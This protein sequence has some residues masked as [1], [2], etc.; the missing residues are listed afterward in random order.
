[1][2]LGFGGVYFAVQTTEAETATTPTSKDQLYTCGMHPQ[3]IS[4]KP[5][6]CPICNMKLTPKRDAGAADGT[7]RIDPAT[8]QNMGLVTSAARYE[9]LKSQIHTFGE[10]A[11]PDPNKY[12]ITVKFDGWVERLFVNEEGKQVHRGEPLLEVYSPDLVTARKELLVAMMSESNT[13]MDRLAEAARNRLLNWDISEEQLDRLTESGEINRTMIIHSPVDGFVKAK[14]V[15]EGDRVTSQS[16]LYEITDLSTVWIKAT[17]YEQDLPFLQ[18][19]G[20]AQVSVPSLPGHAFK[21]SI[22]YISPI[23]NKQGQVEIRLTLNNPGFILKP[24]MYA[25]VTLECSL[26]GERL[27]IPRSAVINSG[28]RQLVYVSTSDDSYKPREVTTGAVGEND[29]IEVVDGLVSGDPVVTS[30]Q[31]LLDSETRLSEAVQSSSSNMSGNHNHIAHTDLMNEPRMHADSS[32]HDMDV[33]DP[34]NIHT[35]PMP[36]H[37]H[38]LHYGPEACPE[39]G[40]DLVPFNE[41]ENSPVYVCPMPECKVATREPGLCPVCN[42][43]LI[44]YKPEATSDR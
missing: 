24:A 33:N 29:M 36:A 31:F 3:I 2:I 27:V 28:I 37:Y 1:M 40:M 34:Y 14:Y 9:I 22:D 26:K 17:A 15:N 21:G 16:L 11:I 10:V 8:R 5:G 43:K 20:A 12:S 25:D 13:T 19:H 7:V 41:T 38:V 42:M 44:E 18:L 23:L 32:D 6:I 4:D 30:G 35:C 39:C